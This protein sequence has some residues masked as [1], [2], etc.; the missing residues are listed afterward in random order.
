M[1]L[2]DQT[3]LQNYKGEIK[4]FDRLKGTLKYGPSWYPELQSQ[5]TV[6]Q[7]LERILVKGYI[8]LRNCTLPGSEIIIPFI[9]IGPPGVIVAYVTHLRGTYMAKGDSWRILRGK[10]FQPAAV[11]LLTRVEQYARAL[12]VFI[13]RQ[14]A[15]QALSIDAVLLAANPGMYIETQRPTV[16]I[17]MSDALERWANGLLQ[18]PPILS[19]AH[20]EQLA[21]RIVNPQPP[22]RKATVQTETTRGPEFSSSEAQPSRAQAIFQASENAETF[23]PQ[24]LS[25]AFDEENRPGMP[26]SMGETS[27]AIPIPASDSARKIFLGLTRNQLVLLGGMALLEVCVL[28]CLVGFLFLFPQ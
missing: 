7:L 4:L 14:G 21:E 5:K 18:S 17:V 15:K 6:I 12:K 8:L 13:Q 16:R 10:N 2:I 19:P 28:V 25:F 3:P 11:N 23:N 27:P 1:K 22:K 9:L 20:V 24:E 26:R